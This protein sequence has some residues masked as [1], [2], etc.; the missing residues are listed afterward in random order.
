M[1]ESQAKGNA[2]FYFI[3]NVLQLRPGTDIYDAVYRCCCV[4][5]IFLLAWLCIDGT[6][7]AK[8]VKFVLFKVAHT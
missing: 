6:D 2:I 1:D 8:E 4:F 3:F 5:V 7:R